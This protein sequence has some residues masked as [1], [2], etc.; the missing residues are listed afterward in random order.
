MK[1]LSTYLELR[2]MYTN[3]TFERLVLAHGNGPLVHAVL[4]K[5]RVMIRYVDGNL[6]LCVPPDEQY[7]V[8]TNTVSGYLA[9]R[10]DQESRDKLAQRIAESIGATVVAETGYLV[11]KVEGGFGPVTYDEALGAGVYDSNDGLVAALW[12]E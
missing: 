6:Y 2:E 4:Y 7:R 5:N 3:V 9:T 11:K 10:P 1:V 12:Q 8:V